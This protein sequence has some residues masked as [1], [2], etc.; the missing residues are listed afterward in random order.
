MLIDMYFFKGLI[1]EPFFYLLVTYYQL[2]Q[3]KGLSPHI[4]TQLFISKNIMKN[5]F[6]LELTTRRQFNLH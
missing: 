4:C 2:Q 5:V 6:M 3:Y 1:D